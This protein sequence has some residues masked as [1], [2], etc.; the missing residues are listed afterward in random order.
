LCLLRGTS[1]EKEMIMRR[2]TVRLV[3]MLA[4]VLFTAPLAAH[5]QPATKVYRIGRLSTGSL[6]PTPP[7]GLQATANSLRF[8]AAIGGA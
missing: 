2:K 3:V 7:A 5:V 4:L 1:A 6:P 8:A